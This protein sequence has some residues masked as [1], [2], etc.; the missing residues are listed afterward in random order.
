M[1]WSLVLF[2]LLPAGCD[3]AWFLNEQERDTARLR[4]MQD[5]VNSL[6]AP[7]SWK[8]AFSE[9]YSPHGY[10]RILWAFVSGIIL[11]SN[12]NFLAMIIKRLGYS[13]VKTNLVRPF[14]I[15]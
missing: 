14:Y 5:S 9:F 13:V 6:R 7:F 1:L 12:A 8:E 2:A 10:I 4:L 3:T 15:G 11:T